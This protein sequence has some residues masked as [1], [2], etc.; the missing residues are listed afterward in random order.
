MERA[1]LLIKQGY[2]LFP[3]STT[4][5][6]FKYNSGLFSMMQSKYSK[7]VNKYFELYYHVAKDLQPKA[8]S[9]Q[10]DPSQLEKFAILNNLIIAFMLKESVKVDFAGMDQ[11]Y[12]ILRYENVIDVR[13]T[14]IQEEL[15]LF[16]LVAYFK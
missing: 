10:V 7:A 6:H 4:K 12:E 9:T 8:R 14:Q 2:M 16:L 15:T 5:K 1:I 3:H 13:F 11:L